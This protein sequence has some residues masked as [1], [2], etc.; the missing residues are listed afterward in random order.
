M[1]HLIALCVIILGLA[2]GYHKGFFRQLPFL[3]GFSFG[4]VCAR[5]FSAPVEDA[6]Y[7]IFPSLGAKAEC[8]YVCSAVSRGLVFMFV[9]EVFSVCTSF[10]KLMFRSYTSGV[11]DSLA[12]M[13]FCA[14]RY[15]LILS[16]LLNWA[17]CI[18]PRGD[19]LRSA[20]SDDG[21]IIEEVMLVAPA[22]LGGE[23]VED[24]AHSLQ[25][26]DAKCIS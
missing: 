9:Y 16:I 5:L 6:L 13:L 3:I 1:I 2:K 26:E 17:L 10:L 18:H 20:K 11:L 14:L 23:S 12:G 15:L 7:E 8:D 22:I 25:L 21:N 24:L 4:V 19:L